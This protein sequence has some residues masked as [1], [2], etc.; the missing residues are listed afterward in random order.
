MFRNIK[1]FNSTTSNDEY[2]Y[3]RSSQPDDAI[4]LDFDLYEL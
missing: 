4:L 1:V 2:T 3:I